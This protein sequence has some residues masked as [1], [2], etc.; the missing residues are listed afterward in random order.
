MHYIVFKSLSE[1]HIYLIK[2]N[3]KL[4]KYHIKVVYIIFWL[5]WLPEDP[6]LMVATMCNKYVPELFLRILVAF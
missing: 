5:P 6:C 1:I 4:C 3:Q 2:C